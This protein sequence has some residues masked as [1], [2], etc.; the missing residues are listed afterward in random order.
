MLST[1]CTASELLLV[2]NAMTYALLFFNT[3]DSLTQA[4]AISK[5]SSR[6]G[7]VC[8]RHGGACTPDWSRWSEP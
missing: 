3:K 7:P 8:P 5:Q 2:I 6:C 4:E 1:K